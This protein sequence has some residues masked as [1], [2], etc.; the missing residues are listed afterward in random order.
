VPAARITVFSGD[1]A[2]PAPDLAVREQQPEAAFW[3]VEGAPLQP[4]LRTPVQ[5]VS[6]DLPGV[7]LHPAARAALAIWFLT[8]RTPAPQ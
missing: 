4:R 1:G 7:V 2:D 3:L 5:L 6:S 8:A